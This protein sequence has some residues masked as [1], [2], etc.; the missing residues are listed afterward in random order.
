MHILHQ[1]ETQAYTSRK[2]QVFHMPHVLMCQTRVTALSFHYN[3]LCKKTTKIRLS[4]VKNLL[5]IHSAILTQIKI[6]TER[7]TE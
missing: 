1:F 4:E 7:Q 6:M 3:A 5:M 2:L